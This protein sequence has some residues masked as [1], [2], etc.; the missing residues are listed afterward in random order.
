MSNRIYSKQ[1]KAVARMENLLNALQPLML[2]VIAIA[3]R[4]ITWLSLAAK[5]AVAALIVTWGLSR[6]TGE[7]NPPK[8]YAQ[9]PELLSL[10]Q[11]AASLWGKHDR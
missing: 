8:D 11:L 3:V 4:S 2:S 9:T 7:L 5:K 1:T 10:K 6:N